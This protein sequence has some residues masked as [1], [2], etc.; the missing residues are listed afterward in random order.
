M[1]DL[2]DCQKYQPEIKRLT[3]AN[4][5]SYEFSGYVDKEFIEFSRVIYIVK[6]DITGKAIKLFVAYDYATKIKL[7]A[8][9][10]KDILIEYIGNQDLNILEKEDG[11][12][13]N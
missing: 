5:F 12:E 9:W 11:K 13:K 2:K 10:D 4:S 7:S 1:I 3:K 6:K 8:H